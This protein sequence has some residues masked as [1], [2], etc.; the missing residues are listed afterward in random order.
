MKTSIYAPLQ[1]LCWTIEYT[2]I[3]QVLFFFGTSKGCN[4]YNLK[5]SLEKIIN[6]MLK[7][8][9]FSTK[10]WSFFLLN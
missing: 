3:G 2:L 5:A 9:E 10:M 1:M 8:L 6:F 4:I 7:F